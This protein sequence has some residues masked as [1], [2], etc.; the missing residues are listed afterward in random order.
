MEYARNMLD[1]LRD[2]STDPDRTDAQRAIFA[3]R[4]R[5]WAGEV[6]RR[7]HAPRVDTFV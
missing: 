5:C 2:A 4:A 6:L 3:M 1:T 7:V